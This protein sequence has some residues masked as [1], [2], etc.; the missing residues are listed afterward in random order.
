[1]S[2]SEGGCAALSKGG[3]PHPKPPP[4]ID[5]AGNAG[6]RE[7]KGVVETPFE[8][9]PNKIA[10]AKPALE[11][12]PPPWAD[13]RFVRYRKAGARTIRD[14]AFGSDC[15]LAV[16]FPSDHVHRAERRDDVGHHLPL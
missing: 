15:H 6:A 11:H 16:E 5:C 3:A 1:M 4:D 9:P 8:H 14:H 10:P 12:A 13:C 2:N 7:S